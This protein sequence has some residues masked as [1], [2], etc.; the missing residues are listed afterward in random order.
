MRL[1]VFSGCPA[2]RNPRHPLAVLLEGTRA[3]RSACQRYELARDTGEEVEFERV[4][5]KARGKRA[6]GGQKLGDAIAEKG[7]FRQV[8]R[9][10][11]CEKGW[12]RWLARLKLRRRLD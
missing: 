10:F 1:S 2:G 8:Q 6:S 11:T 7:S 3:I 9:V 12:T 5:E 4:R